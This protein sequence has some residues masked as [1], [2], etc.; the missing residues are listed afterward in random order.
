MKPH[1]FAVLA[2]TAAAAFF[3]AI[4]S[5]VASVPWSAPGI[6]KAELLFP[7]LTAAG[8]ELAALE[9]GR[10]SDAVRVELRDGN[11]VLAS[12]EGYPADAEKVRQLILAASEARLVEAKTA[13]KDRHELLGLNDPDAPGSP[14]RRLRFIDSSNAPMGETIL[15][16]TT[17]DAFE[18][19]KGGT[20][21]RSPGE[22]QTWL[23]D[24]QITASL[25]M[26]DWVKTRL[27]DVQPAAIKSI[28]IEHEGGEAFD[29]VRSDDGKSHQLAVMPEGK[30]LKYVSAADDIA[31]AV[32][33]IEFRNV[34]KAGKAKEL[35]LKG[36][37]IFET[38]TGYKPVIEFRS[39]GSAVWVFVSATGEGAASADAADIK[40]RAEGWEF[41]VP[42][43]ELNAV[44][45]KLA[46]LLEDVP[47]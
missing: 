23:V 3:M 36:R 22:D 21:I 5:Y 39:D 25:S 15:G 33:L 9:V 16:R 24:R 1:H 17:F 12:Q 31:E 28:R 46:D 42:Q 47:S 26:R 27:I 43:A 18:A 19:S 45:V 41:E 37:A 30:K 14:A 13:L 10:G 29:I 35:P 44:M 6:A 40:Q 38:E 20:Y 7:R 11:F 8:A 32:S 34:R 4:V 2:V